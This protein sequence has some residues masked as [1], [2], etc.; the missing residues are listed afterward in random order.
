MAFHKLN[1]KI[2]N[3]GAIVIALPLLLVIGSGLFLQL[4]KDFDWIQ[5]PTVNG[6]NKALPA[7]T[8]ED[9]LARVN[10]VPQATG[11]KWQ[12]FD[13]IDFKPNK[14]MA[15]FIT[16]DNYEI[17]IDITTGEILSVAYRRSDIIESLHDG[18]FF[19]DF[20]KYYVILPSGIALFILWMSGIY[21]FFHPRLQKRKKKKAKKKTRKKS[22][23]V[24]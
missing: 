10:G 22:Y 14:G 11:L 8:F 23:D 15:K 16:P 7:L 3:W 4:K 18:T 6:V 13:R 20:A 5:P 12:E 21:M 24:V 1:R 19:G 2:H 17:Q 9:V